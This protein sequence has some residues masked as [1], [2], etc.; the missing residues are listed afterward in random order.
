MPWSRGFWAKALLCLGLVGAGITSSGSSSASPGQAGTDHQG[1]RTA[2][3][4]SLVR[5]ALAYHDLI[6]DEAP[7]GKVV[8]DIVVYVAEVLDDRDPVPNFLNFFHARTK[9]FIIRQEVLQP[10]GKKWDLGRVLETERNLRGLRQLSVA[11][12]V[13][14]RGRDDSRVILVVVVKD[15]WSLR[16]NS[17]IDYGSAGLNYLVLNPTEENLA[18]LRANLG[19]YYLLE[20]ERYALGVSLGYPRLPG[21]RY[22]VSLGG[23]LYKNRETGQNEGAYGGF[24]FL[25]PQFSR[26]S[27]WAYGAE[28]NFR[29]GISRQYQD[30]LPVT[31]QVSTPLHGSESVPLRYHKD[32]LSGAYYGLRSFGV[33]H[34]FDIEFGITASLSRYRPLD[35]QGISKLALARF[36]EQELPVSDTRI[37]PYVS[38]SAYETR[39]FRGTNIE[40]LGLQ[41]DF[42]L[43]YAFASSLFGGNEELGSSRDYI[44]SRSSL[45]YTQELG[46]GFL[47]VGASNR[48]VVANHGRHEGYVQAVGRLVTPRLG[49]GRLHLD[50]YFGYRYQDYLN[51]G[52][53]RI[54][55]DNRMRGYP[56]SYGEFHGVN[57]IFFNAEYRTVGVD[58][59]S[60]QVGLAAFYDLGGV[61]NDL[62]TLPIRH[63]AGAGVR[64]VFPQ[65]GREIFRMDFGVPLS[66][67]LPRVP[68]SFI[69]TFGHAFPMPN[70]A[71]T[72]GPFTD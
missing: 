14:A 12:V 68:S 59:L 36:A 34:K 9:D 11:N 50:G 17:D 52:E 40:S 6:L 28:M 1:K 8:E 24:S 70:S 47:R 10:I 67:D 39:F 58:V 44:G 23:G 65:A 51:V 69:L 61:G 18:G 31:V 32:Q 33:E 43:G 71:G 72:G 22:S 38:V 63:S 48:T 20:R 37:G 15:V 26:F 49:L 54:G 3:E 62:A 64:V 29:F 57:A 2:L 16:L 60:A 56:P 7:E 55:V 27:K 41:E 19:G 13:A 35:E 42:R 21:S 46:R 66:G 30:G 45:G 4:E 25:L 53:F 5:E